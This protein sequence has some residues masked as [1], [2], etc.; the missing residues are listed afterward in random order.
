MSDPTA[1]ASADRTNAAI[2]WVLVA[3]VAL[4]A[5]HSALT[6]QF[7][8]SGFE[9]GFVVLVALPA[10]VADDWRVLAPW[11]LLLVGAASFV[12]QSVGLHQEF[13]GY[14]AVAAFALVGVAQLDAFTGVE[15]SRRFSIAFAALT[16]MA[17]QGVWTIGRYASDQLLGSDY[18]RSQAQIQWDF[19]YVTLVAVVIGGVFEL[20]F[21]RTETDGSPDEPTLRDS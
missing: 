11:P 6:R 5:V 17:V 16:T 8:W 3:A 18:I 7:L 9:V 14:T 20:Y 21:R 1:E 10:A 15:M 13:T 2:G 12:G 19:V 4:S